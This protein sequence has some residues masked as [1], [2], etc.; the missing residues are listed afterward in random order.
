MF[1]GRNR[2]SHEEQV[3]LGLLYLNG[4]RPEATALQPPHTDSLTPLVHLKS[5]H[6]IPRATTEYEPFLPS[7][8]PAPLNH[9]RLR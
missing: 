6:S 9:S 1:R 8:T 7:V 2:L 4:A 3:L 5:P